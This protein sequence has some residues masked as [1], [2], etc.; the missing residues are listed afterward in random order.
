[1]AF[2][3]QLA[4]AQIEAFIAKRPIALNPTCPRAPAAPSAYSPRNNRPA[5]GTANRN[6]PDAIGFAPRRIRACSPDRSIHTDL[7]PD[8]TSVP[9]YLDKT[10]YKAPAAPFANAPCRCGFRRKPYRRP[11]EIARPARSAAANGKNAAAIPCRRPPIRLSR[12]Y[13]PG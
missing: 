2:A 11:P 9:F 1:M 4:V 3:L 7:F 5:S 12:K 10:M 8:R 6:R 13:P